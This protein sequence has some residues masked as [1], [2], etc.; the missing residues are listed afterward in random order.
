MSRFGAVLGRLLRTTEDVVGRGEILARGL[1]PAHCRRGLLGDNVVASLRLG[2]GFR[3][4]AL[5]KQRATEL[6]AS[7]AGVQMIT[8]L[9]V[10]EGCHGRSVHL[11]GGGEVAPRHIYPRE[12]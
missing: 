2:L 10:S 3:C 9:C 4:A 11:L 12:V 8:R 1:E 7:D 6:D 5:T